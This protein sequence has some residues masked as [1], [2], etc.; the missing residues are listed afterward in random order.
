MLDKPAGLVVHPAP[1]NAGRHIGQCP[2]GPLRA[3]RLAIG[4]ERRPGI[5][6]RLDKDTSGV[7]VVAKTDLAM[8]ALA[9]CLCQRGR[10]SG[11]I[12]RCAGECPRRPRGAIEGAIGRDP[13]RPQAHDDCDTWRQG[14]LNPLPSTKQ[15]WRGFVWRSTECRLAT[16]RT[17]QIRVHLASIRAIRSSATRCICAASL[18][19]PEVCF[20]PIYAGRL[21]DF[22]RQALHAA[23]LGFASTRVRL[24]PL[25][26]ET[27]PP[28]D[29]QALLVALD[30]RSRKL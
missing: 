16:G 2:A 24:S 13:R 3:R 20:R 30:G 18:P 14:C 26:F 4:G 29:F 21:L 11:P 6:H 23:V 19:H 15:A 22:P 1:G 9:G 10:S 12:S 25:R 8:A 17:H 27:P 7:M 5:V 28:A